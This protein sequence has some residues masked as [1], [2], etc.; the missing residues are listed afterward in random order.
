MT[1]PA[2]NGS[3]DTLFA[4]TLPARFAPDMAAINLLTCECSPASE[5]VRAC[6]HVCLPPRLQ[7]NLYLN[8]SFSLPLEGGGA[9]SAIASV[10]RE[11][12]RKH[13]SCP[14]WKQFACFLGR[15]LPQ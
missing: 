11:E 10:L 5:R 14:H 13:Y 4:Y 2:I 7:C 15:T 6:V 9:G 1:N 12:Q 3:S 8:T